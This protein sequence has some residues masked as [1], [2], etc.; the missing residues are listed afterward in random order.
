MTV[1]IQWDW[2]SRI[3]RGSMEVSATFTHDVVQ[4]MFALRAI[5]H[6]QPQVDWQPRRS[7]APHRGAY[8]WPMQLQRRCFSPA[9]F[10]FERMLDTG[11]ASEF[12][13]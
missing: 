8:S 5:F 4:R 10:L 2:L 3:A 7:S 13:V 11:R 1:R 12:D 6:G 9:L